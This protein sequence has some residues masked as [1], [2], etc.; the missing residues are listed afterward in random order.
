MNELAETEVPVAARSPT[1][2]GPCGIIATANAHWQWVCAV[3]MREYGAMT[4]RRVRVFAF[5]LSVLVLAACTT[6]TIATTGGVSITPT[7]PP[8]GIVNG[9]F[10]TGTFAGWTV[11]GAPSSIATVAHSG[12]YAA[13]LGA[14][15]PTNGD[16]SIS[17]TFTM[18]SGASFVTFWY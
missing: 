9:G 18:P 16:S 6:G 11:S 13:M 3:G 5:P 2:L 17:Q 1:V 15:S 4:S 12:S 8:S 10:E 7:P 14:T